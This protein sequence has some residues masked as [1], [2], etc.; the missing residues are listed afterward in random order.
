M[1][2]LSRAKLLHEEKQLS[3]SQQVNRKGGCQ[4]VK[5][6]RLSGDTLLTGVLLLDSGVNRSVDGVSI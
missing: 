6:M 5:E 1:I 2:H 4:G 3:I